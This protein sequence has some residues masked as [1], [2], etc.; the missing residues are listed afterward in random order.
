MPRD[1][2]LADLFDAI[3]NRCE[4]DASPSM[5]PRKMIRPLY[6]VRDFYRAHAAA[7]RK[8]LREKDDGWTESEAR[9]E[10]LERKRE[11]LHNLDNQVT[12]ARRHNNHATADFID[13]QADLLRAEI[14]LA[15]VREGK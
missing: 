1:S 11:L 15:G 10:L 12:A 5:C 8:I 9:A 14:A 13:A 6:D 2:A 7:L 3:A 4:E